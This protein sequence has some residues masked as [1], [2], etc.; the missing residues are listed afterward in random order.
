M[1][2]IDTAFTPQIPEQIIDCNITHHINEILKW[3]FPNSIWLIDLFFEDIYFKINPIISGFLADDA[4]LGNSINI[5]SW[6]T[7]S[8]NFS[9]D[10]EIPELSYGDSLSLDLTNLDYGIN[11]QVD[12]LMGY[13][14]GLG[15][16]WFF[17]AG[18]EYKLT[19]WPNSNFDLVPIEGTIRLKTWN[20]GNTTWI[21][22]LRDDKPMIASYNIFLILS[23]L[24]II[25]GI[26]LKKKVNN[27]KSI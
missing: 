1:I 13:D 9:L 24:G 14:T 27:Q 18:D 4:K 3:N 7:T 21:S 2:T 6:E 26:V 16:F 8:K 5:L 15:I 25:S 20:A 23:V 11:F 10:L 19:T 12:W 22:D 17:G